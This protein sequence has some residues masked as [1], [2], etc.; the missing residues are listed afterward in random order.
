M[1][2]PN[3]THIP[4]LDGLRGIAALSV[5][6]AH[7]AHYGFLPGLLGGELGKIGVAVF[8]TLSGFLMA[9]LHLDVALTGAAIGRYAVNR[10][11]RILPLTYGAVALGC[12]LLL[13]LG[14][15][16]YVFETLPEILRILAFVEGTGVLWSI[17]VEVQ[18]Y[19]LFV[20][21]W[22]LP[23]RFRLWAGGALM[24]LQAV[25]AWSL[26]SAV[27]STHHLIFWLHFFL[28]GCGV[29]LAA[30]RL[31]CAATSPLARPFAWSVALAALLV[32][33]EVRTALGVPQTWPFLDPVSAGWPVLALIAALIGVGPFRWLSTGWLRWLGAVSFAVYLLH[34]PVIH[35][36]SRLGPEGPVGFA[37]I[38]IVTLSLAEV[39][40]RWFE[41]PA[42]A[43]IKSRLL[44]SG[45][46]QAHAV[47][48]E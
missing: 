3:T 7:A 24:V 35:A 25:L 47:P 9:R 1:A 15:S 20:A 11:A 36:V 4:T 27:S 46:S 32:P 30:D 40:R 23:A 33:P 22:L 19:A 42:A 26:L 14:G 44:K 48:A 39:S 34:M 10:I 18:F 28:I 8:F 45:R 41:R 16:G 6:L 43:V 5:L 37:F 2:S 21:L 13:G 38:L 29:A 12:V 31:A 17:P